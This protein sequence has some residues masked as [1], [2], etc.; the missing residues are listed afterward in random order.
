MATSSLTTAHRPD[1]RV[2]QGEI[3]Y[4]LPKEAPAI[5]DLTSRG[6]SN[7][8]F[9][10]RRVEIT[11][12]RPDVSDYELAT[13]GFGLFP[14]RSAYADPSDHDALLRNYH[15]EMA[16]FVKRVSGARDVIPIR[17]GLVIRK[18]VRAAVAS[19][20]Q[21]AH[22]AHTDFTEEW[23]RNFVWVAMAWEGVKEIEDY[24][25]FAI[26]QTWRVTSPP[27]QDEALALCEA[28]AVSSHDLVTVHT[29]P[30]PEGTGIQFDSQLVKYNPA[31]RWVYFSGMTSHETLIFKGYD[32][33][34]S[35][36]SFVP[37]AAFRNPLVSDDVEPRS[38]IEA[39]FLTFFD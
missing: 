30:R 16:E 6:R 24:S 8:A 31:H 23:A 3:G 19:R 28:T 20:S 25:R 5:I 17:N 34:S 21:T 4:F 7:V 39:R 33:D 9:E 1:P 27:P 37:H 32:S 22:F 11:D 13:Q 29:K 15:P 10:R 12:A 2:V 35:Q 18:G 38:S 36:P 14:H 26:Y